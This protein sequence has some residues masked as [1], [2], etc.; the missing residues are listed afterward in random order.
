MNLNE[1]E[2][3]VKFLALAD[4]KAKNMLLSD[5]GNESYDLPYQEPD[6]YLEK[7]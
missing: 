6:N 1:V 5:N 7:I 4:K 3:M 2:K